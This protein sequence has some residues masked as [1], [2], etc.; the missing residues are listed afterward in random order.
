MRKETESRRQE[1]GA[2]GPSH[3]CTHQTLP[4]STEAVEKSACMADF[5]ELTGLQEPIKEGAVTDIQ[6][7][8]MNSGQCE[9]LREALH[10]NARRDKRWKYLS[11]HHLATSVGMDYLN[12]S[13]VAVTYVP[14]G[15]LWIWSKD[16]SD[17]AM[18]EFRQWIS[19]ARK[20]DAQ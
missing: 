10:R 8:W 13:P 6:Q 14:W 2:A 9:A 11:D 5:F 17:I 7:V 16:D 19:T 12:Y 18:K 1:G 20:G 15:Q 3:S 4:I